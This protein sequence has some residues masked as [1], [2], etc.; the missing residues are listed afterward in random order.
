MRLDQYLV[1]NSFYESRNKA[2]YEIKNSKVM[3]NNKI[4]TKASFDVSDSDTVKV[5]D[6]SLIYVSKG[7]LKLEKALDYFKIDPHGFVC[8]DIGSSTGGFTD[9]LLKRGASEVYAVDVGTD[10]LHKSLR[11]DMRVHLYENTNF[12]SFD[13]SQLK[14]LDIIV[15]DVSFIKVE[16]I[17]ERVIDNFKDVIVVFLIKPQFE[18]GHIYLKGGVVKEEA[19]HNKAINQVIEFLK[20]KNVSINEVIESPILGGSGNK[21]YLTIIKI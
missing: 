14:K 17:L 5:L 4:V 6:Q 12:L 2:Q 9:C 18:L 15:T 20:S 3:V 16:T 19:L 10:Q 7:G 21:E 11:E 1:N 13:L 8:L